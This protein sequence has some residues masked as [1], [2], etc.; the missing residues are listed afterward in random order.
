MT[1]SEFKQIM[2]FV[3]EK[4]SLDEILECFA[5]AYQKLD[6]PDREAIDAVEKRARSVMTK[7]GRKTAREFSAGTG[8]ALAY[9]ELPTDASS[10][11]TI[12][13]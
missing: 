4:L 10:F 8:M 9:Q 13:A 1:D 5:S 11:A 6:E 12:A 3:R 7:V 2:K